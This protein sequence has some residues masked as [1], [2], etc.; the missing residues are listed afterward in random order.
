L[1]VIAERTPDHRRPEHRLIH[2]DSA[3]VPPSSR[4]CIDGVYAQMRETT[5]V[6]QGRQ[7]LETVIFDYLGALR[8]GDQEALR[9]VLDPNVTWQGLP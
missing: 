3:R 7:N 9:E 1:R 8:E 2:R 6:T 5:M 4:R